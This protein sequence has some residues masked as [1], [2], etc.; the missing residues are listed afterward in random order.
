MERERWE[1]EEW[2]GWAPP[3]I[4]RKGRGERCWHIGYWLGWALGQAEQL[5]PRRPSIFYFFILVF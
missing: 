4:E 3:A 2:E 5:R 1:G